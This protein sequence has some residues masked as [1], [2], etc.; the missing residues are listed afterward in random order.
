MDFW[1]LAILL[2]ALGFCLK[3]LEFFFPSGGIFVVCAVAVWGVA[4]YFGFCSG[5]Y[6]GL[7]MS[8]VVVIGVPIGFALMLRYWPQTSMGRSVLLT[9]PK[10]EDVT[11]DDTWRQFLKSLVGRVGRAKCKMLP[12][13]VIEIDGRTFEAA[14]VGMAIDEGQTVRVVKVQANRLIVQ[15]DTETPLPAEYENPLD[16]PIESMDDPFGDDPFREVG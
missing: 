10:T 11:P 16:R 14:T 3:L 5:P 8:T 2:L 15:P 13:G 12:S 1:V 4:I 9:A 7:G 6:F